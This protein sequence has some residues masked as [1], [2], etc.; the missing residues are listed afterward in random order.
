MIRFLPFCTLN[1]LCHSFL[2]CSLLLHNQLIA[3]WGIVPW[4][5]ALCF[6]L[7]AFKIL[8]LS[9]T[10]A[11]LIMICLTVGLFGFMLF[12]ILSVSYTWVSISFFKFWN[13]LAIISTIFSIFFLLSFPSGT[14]I[15]QI[16]ICF[17]LSPKS[18]VF[19]F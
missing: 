12:G 19:V 17:I 9:L 6:S 14:L 15:I 2:G 18:L 7:A 13:F 5:M 4:Y 11:I 10:F 8:F 16:L 1:V 3:F